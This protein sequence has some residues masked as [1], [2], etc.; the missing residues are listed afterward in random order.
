MYIKTDEDHN[1]VQFVKVGG[2]DLTDPSW[3][4]IPYDEHVQSILPDIFSYK[5]I[6]GEFV[7]RDDAENKHV[8]DAKEQ[9]IKFLSEMCQTVIENGI[10]IGDNHYSLTTTDQMNL[11]KL[12]TQAMMMPDLP[13]FYHSDGHLC[14]QYTPEQITQIATAGVAWVTYHTTYFNFARAYI[15]SLTDFDTIASF[16]YGSQIED[17][18]LY[19]Q[20]TA[21][22]STTQVTFDTEIDDPFDYDALRNP[23]A[24]FFQEPS[25]EEEIFIPQMIFDDP[26]DEYVEEVLTYEEEPVYE[27]PDQEPDL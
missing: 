19:E 8:Q 22:T 17:Q 10:Q 12:A 15:E 21:I 20:M 27:E 18:S 7:K 25:E 11:S 6:D 1:I 9:K 5:F 16:K 2:A 13:L 24:D 4:E 3:S 23:M 26:S 14:H